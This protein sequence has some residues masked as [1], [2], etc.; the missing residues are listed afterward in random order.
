MTTGSD[1]YASSP[2]DG[3]LEFLSL[4][5]RSLATP[6]VS[7]FMSR[8]ADALERHP[9]CVP[10]RIGL[11]DPASTRIINLRSQLVELAGRQPVERPARVLLGSPERDEHGTVNYVPDPFKVHPP[12]FVTPSAIELGLRPTRPA[13]AGELLVDLAEATHAFYGLVTWTRH[14]R[15]LRGRFLPDQNERY[16]GSPSGGRPPA[17]QPP[18]FQ[19]MEMMVPDVFWVQVFGPAFVEMWGEDRLEAAGVRRRRLG[20][21]GYAVWASDVPPPYDDVVDRPEGYGWKHSVYDAIGPEPFLRAD[22]GWNDFGV[23]VPLMT[24]HAAALS[25]CRATRGGE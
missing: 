5:V 10:T 17:W 21:G 9:G 23:H 6:G 2:V 4:E 15:Q 18:R 25:G 24:Q 3:V 16:G 11:R 14:S 12:G 19:A 13:E 1:L 8:V 22:R 20:Y 7:T